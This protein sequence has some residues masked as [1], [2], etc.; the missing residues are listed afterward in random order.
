MHG[1]ILLGCGLTLGVADGVGVGDSEGFG[2]NLSQHS[3]P[4]RLSVKHLN[5]VHLEENC[6]RLHWRLA[7][8]FRAVKE[9][10]MKHLQG[11]GLAGTGGTRDREREKRERMR[12]RVIFMVLVL[13]SCFGG[14]GDVVRVLVGVEGRG[15]EEERDGIYVGDKWAILR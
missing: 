15:G 1:Q 4:M 6:G 3:K 11:Q 2:L 12:K 9:F 7:I 13:V 8:D 14:G 10:L 5:V